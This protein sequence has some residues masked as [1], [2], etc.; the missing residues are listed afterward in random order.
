MGRK[1]T[2]TFKEIAVTAAQ[3]LFEIAA[4]ADAVVIVHDW[5]VTQKTETG[6]TAEEMLTLTTN[7]GIGS[8]T[9][10]SGGASVTPH[11]VEDGDAAFGGTVERNNTTIMAVGSGT[12]DT[13]LEVHTW[14]V[15][16]PYQKIYTPETR[17]VISPSNR[18]TLEL[19][20]APADSVTVSGTVT[21]EEV[22]G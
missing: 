3:D 13:D 16:M 5:T 9:S 14:N 12:L 4:P 19:E 10:G 15:R 18:W 2:A 1:Y 21:F 8:V 22:G 7:R 17:P 6:D 20:T 11:A